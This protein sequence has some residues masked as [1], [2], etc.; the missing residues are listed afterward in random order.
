MRIR[1]A[2]LQLRR[3]PDSAQ[4]I[5]VYNRMRPLFPPVFYYSEQKA[6]EGGGARPVSTHDAPCNSGNRVRASRVA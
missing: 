2:R 6:I 3:S 5:I 4:A 1:C